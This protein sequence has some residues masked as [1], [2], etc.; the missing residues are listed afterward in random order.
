MDEVCQFAD[1]KTLKKVNS[2]IKEHSLKD[3]GLDVGV[4]IKL[5]DYEDKVN[6]RIIR[7][8]TILDTSIIRKE[9]DN[10]ESRPSG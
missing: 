1:T 6:E 2:V 8:A 10:D 3:L 9:E 7:K 4:R 5:D